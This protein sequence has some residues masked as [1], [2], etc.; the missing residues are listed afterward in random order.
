MIGTIKSTIYDNELEY[1]RLK[2]RDSNNKS[3]NSN[4]NNKYL[5][6]K[7]MNIRNILLFNF[8]RNSSLLHYHLHTI[9]T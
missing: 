5:K 8:V 1:P 9:P 7:R 4:D 6:I 3:I 2:V